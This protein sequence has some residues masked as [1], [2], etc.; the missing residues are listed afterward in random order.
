[1]NPAEGMY[2]LIAML[3]ISG[4]MGF[5]ITMN[6]LLTVTLCGP[7]AMNIAGTMKDVLLTAAGFLFFPDD[8]DLS[9]SLFIGLGFSFSGATYFSYNKYKQVREQE[10]KKK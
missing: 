8:V 2:G 5:V 10:E 3:M 1:M 7:I 4:V 6:I 9:L